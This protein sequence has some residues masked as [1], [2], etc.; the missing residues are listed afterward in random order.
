M[1]KLDFTMI[2]SAE[3]K[4]IFEIITD[5]EN[6]IKFFPIQLKKI[7]IISKN[8]NYTVTEETI[9]ISSVI[10]KN[11]AQQTRHEILGDFIIDSLIISGPLKGTILRTQLQ[12]E[13]NSTNIH[14]NADIKTSL[15]Y[16]IVMPLIKKEYKNI[17]KAFFY[18]VNTLALQ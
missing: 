6:I 14:I 8:E 12:K 18:K 2:L 1:S 9:S 7:Q 10:K 15:K 3:P 16:R 4:K 13:N 5:Y 17:L 11:F